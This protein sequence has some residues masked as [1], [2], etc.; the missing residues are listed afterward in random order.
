VTEPWLRPAAPL[1]AFGR[2]AGVPNDS[3]PE[4][5]DLETISYTNPAL[6]ASYALRLTLDTV[7]LLV[8]SSAMH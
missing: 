5:E 7:A 2:E 3:W 8:A 1:L 6:D 4:R